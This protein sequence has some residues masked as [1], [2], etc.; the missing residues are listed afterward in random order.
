MTISSPYRILLV[1]LLLLLGLA[2]PLGAQPDTSRPSVPPPDSSTF[3]REGE[4]EGGFKMT[5]SPLLATLLSIVPGG[6]QLYN[7]DYWKVPLFFAAGGFFV[8]RTLYYHNLFIDKVDELEAIPDVD[9]NV[10]RRLTLRTQREFYR[11]NR[12]LNFAYFLGVEILSMIDAYVGAHLF[13]FDVDDDI[14]SRIMLDPER[15]GVRFTMRW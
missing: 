12:D 13:D 9:S 6:G 15:M 10:S 4:P 1:P 5:K 2:M 7:E 8:Y 11:D 14:S 3:T